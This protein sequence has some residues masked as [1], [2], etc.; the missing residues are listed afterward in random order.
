[1]RTATVA[2]SAEALG[3]M[4]ELNR[5]TLEYSKTRKQFGSAIGSFQVLQHRM[6]LILLWPYEQVKSLLYRAVCGLAEDSDDMECIVHALK[7]LVGKTGKQIFGEA[8]Q[9]HGGMGITDE[10]DIGHYAKRLMMINTTF[11]EGS[12]SRK[13]SFAL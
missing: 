7:A 8:I 11:G 2:I 1:M 4:G 13:Q 12:S 9:I 3:I 5:K 10:L 6:N